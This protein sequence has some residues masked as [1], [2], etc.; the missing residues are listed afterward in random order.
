MRDF[1]G[2]LRFAGPARTVVCQDDNVLV[3]SILSEEVD[4]EVLVVDG[5][6]THMAAL[7]GDRLAGIAAR[8]GWAGIVVRGAVRDVSGLGSLPIGVRALG[9]N[10]RKPGKEG[11]GE[12][13]IEV[14]LH[15]VTVVPGDLVLCD[16]D[17]LLVVGS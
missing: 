14:D 2:H 4:G 15:G 1:G 12:S 17:G 5:G 6:E 9:V 11:T 7:V 16:E 3:R 8:N 10:P 13:G